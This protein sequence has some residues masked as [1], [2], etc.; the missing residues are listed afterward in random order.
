MKRNPKQ[1][2][3]QGDQHMI[4]VVVKDLSQDKN[5]RVVAD[6]SAMT[7]KLA[8]SARGRNG[9]FKDSVLVVTSTMTLGAQGI[10]DSLL[11]STDT[12]NLLGLYHWQLELDDGDNGTEVVAEGEFEFVLNIDE[13]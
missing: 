9:Y 1:T 5:G 6:V 10:V 12:A 8:L 7:G 4:R 11:E 13:S 2:F 3:A